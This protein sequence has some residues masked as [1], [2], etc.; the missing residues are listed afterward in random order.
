MWVTL[1]SD[2][3]LGPDGASW[4]VWLRSEAGRIIESSVFPPSVRDS[5]LAE[6]LAVIEGIRIGRVRWPQATGFLVRTD[7]QT[8]VSI[9]RYRAPPHRRADF[10]DAQKTLTSILA[11]D[12]RIRMTWTPGHQRPD[13]VRAWINNRV[14]QLA[15]EARRSPAGRTPQGDPPTRSPYRE[16]PPLEEPPVDPEL[17]ALAQ[18]LYARWWEARPWAW[19]LK[20][21][22][23]WH[24]QVLRSLLF[25]RRAPCDP[26]VRSAARSRDPAVRAKAAIATV[27]TR[28]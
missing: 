27:T 17:L 11:P 22:L 15:R 16:T 8:A 7:S 3:S 21:V 6:I 28:S 4:G 5:N 12:V 18:D 26:W 19:R 13:N 24:V 23:A 14:D 1:Y 20:T 9:L 25:G 2:A 10:R